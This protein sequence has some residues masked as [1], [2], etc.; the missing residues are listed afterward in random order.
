LREYEFSADKLPLFIGG[1]GI[2]VRKQGNAFYAE[3]YPVSERAFLYSFYFPDGTGKSTVNKRKKGIIKE[4]VRVKDLVTNKEVE[5][6]T[7]QGNIGWTFKLLPGH[8]Y[9]IY[10]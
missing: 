7:K 8:R 2:L 5:V 4:N 1:D 3:I 10:K 9:E 6:E